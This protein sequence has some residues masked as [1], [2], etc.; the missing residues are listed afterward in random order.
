MME[1][2]PRDLPHRRFGMFMP[3]SMEFNR[4]VWMGQALRTV[5]VIDPDTGESVLLNDAVC[6]TPRG[7]EKMKCCGILYAGRR[8]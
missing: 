4:L 1:Y 5:T 7:R 3:D 8:R 2:I 6:R